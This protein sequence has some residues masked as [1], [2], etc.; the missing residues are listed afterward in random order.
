MAAWAV[1]TDHPYFD[2]TEAD[3]A[4]ELRD[5]PVGTYTLEAWHPTLGLKTAKVKVKKG[6]TAKAT[7]SFAAPAARAAAK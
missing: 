2:V 4:F 5:V 1:V 6:K 3:G 7:F